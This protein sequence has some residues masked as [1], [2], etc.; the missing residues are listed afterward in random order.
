VR[1]GKQ[2]SGILSSESSEAAEVA[3]QK[4]LD[5]IDKA[6]LLHPDGQL[7]RCIITEAWRKESAAKFL[8]PYLGD[9]C[10]SGETSGYLAN[11]LVSVWKK[12]ASLCMCSWDIPP[13][14]IKDANNQS[15][16]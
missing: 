1:T 16:R 12:L 10:G 7:L 6:N 5:F 15:P 14:R 3:I 11:H 4:A 8:D 13:T 9:A 2:H